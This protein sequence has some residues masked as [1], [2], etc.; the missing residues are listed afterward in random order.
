MATSTFDKTIYL[1]QSAAE[2][3]AEILEQPAPPRASLGE[4]YKEDNERKVK[5]WLSQFKK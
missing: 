3:L 2:R 1:D 5:E 4:N